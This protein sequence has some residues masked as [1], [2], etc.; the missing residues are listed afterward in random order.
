MKCSFGR[1]TFYQAALNGRQE[2]LKWL[3]ENGCPAEAAIMT[4]LAAIGNLQA[5]KLAREYGCEW[6]HN[7]CF[8]AQK[9]GHLEVVDWLKQNGCPSY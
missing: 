7:A 2:V 6:N 8:V 5:I 4:L 3:R 9:H 1:V